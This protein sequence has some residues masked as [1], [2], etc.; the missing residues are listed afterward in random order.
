MI[1][2]SGQG[3]KRIKKNTVVSIRQSTPV[4]IFVPFDLIL[5]TASIGKN[6]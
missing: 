5:K 2:G 6:Y 4:S 3:R 1:W